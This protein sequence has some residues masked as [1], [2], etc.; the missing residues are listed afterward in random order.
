[1]YRG[2]IGLLSASI[3]LQAAAAEPPSLEAFA[4]F[5]AMTD[6]SISDDGRYL[7]YITELADQ[8]TAVV[9]DRHGAQPPKSVLSSLRRVRKARTSVGANGLTTPACYA[10]CLAR[11]RA[12][13][14][15]RWHACPR[16]KPHSS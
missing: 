7:A 3:A 6:L 5:P 14:V 1:M 11:A 4:R 8:R 9:F 2:L 13:T 15:A 16:L 12:R 10:D